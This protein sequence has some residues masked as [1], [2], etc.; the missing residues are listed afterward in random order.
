MTHVCLVKE[1]INAV[2]RRPGVITEPQE[3]A[4]HFSVLEKQTTN[5]MVH[6]VTDLRFVFVYIQVAYLFGHIVYL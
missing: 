4:L 5:N 1:S 2:E 6:L 3:G